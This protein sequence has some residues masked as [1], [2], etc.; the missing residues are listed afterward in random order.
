[1]SKLH[2]KSY[3]IT[4]G[5]LL[6]F[7]VFGFY[8][9]SGASDSIKF[10]VGYFKTEDYHADGHGKAVLEGGFPKEIT[11]VESYMQFLF[12]KNNDNTLNAGG[13]PQNKNGS[14]FIVC[15]MLGAWPANSCRSKG[16]I[17]ASNTITKNGK[18]RLT[19]ILTGGTV[20]FSI[21]KISSSN[22]TIYSTTQKDFYFV[23]L[24]NSKDAYVFRQT[25]NG[26]TK[27]FRV[28]QDCANPIGDL[29]LE[30]DE[31][32]NW[33]VTPTLLASP[34][35]VS[36]GG[37]IT[38]TLTGVNI[39]DKL[40]DPVNISYQN[41]TTGGG[42]KNNSI[43]GTVTIPAGWL[44]GVPSSPSTS[45]TVTNIADDGL[46]Y[47]R[48]AVAKPMSM[49]NSV[50]NDVYFYG[51]EVCVEVK[52]DPPPIVSTGECRPIKFVIKPKTYGGEYSYAGEYSGS[53]Y[54]PSDT[55]PV[56]A[57]TSK[58]NWGPYTTATEV[59]ATAN[60]TTGDFY[61]VTI[62]ETRNHLVGYTDID[63][64]DYDRP[65][66]DPI[67][68]PL[69]NIKG[70]EQICD[71]DGNCVDDTD[72]PLFGDIIVGYD[73]N[74]IIG[75]GPTY[76]PHRK[77]AYLQYN[78]SD[79]STSTSLSYNSSGGSSWPLPASDGQ[80]ESAGG[81]GPC[82][83]YELSTSINSISSKLEAGGS[84][85]LSPTV[86]STAYHMLGNSVSHTK[87]RTTD[88]YIT[89]MVVLP[90]GFE[91]LKP[92]PAGKNKIEPCSYYNQSSIGS[93]SYDRGSTVINTSGSPSSSIGK[94]IT[95]P[96]VEAG[97]RICV[98]FSVKDN[99]GWD[100]SGTSDS[101]T[102]SFFNPSENCLVVVKKPKVQIW[103][104]DLWTRGSV[105]TSRSVKSGLAYGS[106]TE[107]GIFAADNIFNMA[108]GAALAGTNA[109]GVL[110]TN[111]ICNYSTLSF[112]NVPINPAS[113]MSCTG[114]S[115]SIGNYSGADRPIPDVSAS[116][117]VNDNTQSV[118]YGDV[119][120]SGLSGLYKADG[121]IN[122]TGGN[123]GKGQWVVINAPGSTVNITG[124]IRYTNE[125][126]SNISEIPQVVI[127]ALNINIDNNVRNVD[128]WLVA[129]N[130]YI[131][132]CS[133]VNSATRL[134]V[135]DCGNNLVV[136]GPVMAGNLYLMR[137]A[138]SGVGDDSD[139]P[140]EIFNTRPDAYLWAFSKANTSGRAQTVYSTELPPRF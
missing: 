90:N 47:C 5:F 26:T 69:F 72:K 11:T 44:A 109:S 101:Y 4:F 75:Y 19:S 91:S 71:A 30:E 140:A 116:F 107:Y 76:Y 119:N 14:A 16:Y 53:L 137:T 3:V 93:C 37:T 106:W 50:L 83:N 58:Q 85:S 1:M 8:Y 13:Y 64:V 82:Y 70:Y 9:V 25:I 10:G 46:R 87:S 128:G 60:H 2:R 131:N 124:D 54:V 115:G 120:L 28:F 125:S 92:V 110:A 95:V 102:H 96:D 63:K 56:V 80:G 100:R 139:T 111:N 36:P 113:A 22:N 123:I 88:W 29:G 138:G 65:E 17:D 45:Q 98:A 73:Y 79:G 84:V 38:W 81:I 127:I 133:S 74:D 24:S 104:G 89:T 105:R 57:Y 41:L 39:G 31:N 34:S 32:K 49:V 40:T 112:T 12:N 117:P 23:S 136:N 33:A 20:S 135:N 27:Q 118:G 114:A 77:F 7:F 126:L 42:F 132:T 134:T 86:S 52:K 55:V 108:S 6:L 129:K 51:P 66:K 61:Q 122:I 59:D 43:G 99:D 15:S 103:G 121:N 18:D 68:R 62:K 48:R 130:G 94:N 67:P 97:T 35:V 78:Y 21:E